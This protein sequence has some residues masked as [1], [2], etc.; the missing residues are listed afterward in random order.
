MANEADARQLTNSVERSDRF[1]DHVKDALATHLHAQ[2]DAA[3]PWIREIE[4]IEPKR[5]LRRVII[6]VVGAT[7]SGK[8][9]IINAIL[10]ET[11]LVPTNCMRACTAVV[12]EIA[13][14][15]SAQ[16]DYRAV[17]EFVS[18]REWQDELEVLLGDI[19]TGGK[20]AA[21]VNDDDSEAGIAF[22]K[23]QAVYPHLNKR[24]LPKATVDEL[25]GCD[26]IKHVVGT[27]IEFNT[28]TAEQLHEQIQK[29]VD[30]KEKLAEDF[31]T[32]GLQSSAALDEIAYWP[33]I[34]TVKIYTKSP[35]LEAG[36]VLVDLPGVADSNAARAAI[37]KKYLEKCSALWIVAPI[38]RAVDDKS[39][40]HLMSEGFK[41]QLWRD[42]TIQRMTFICSKTDEISISEARAAL[43]RYPGSGEKFEAIDKDRNAAMSERDVLQL[44]LSQ[45]KQH[46]E[47]VSESQKDAGEEEVAYKNLQGRA[48]VYPL[49]RVETAKR[50]LNEE[51]LSASSTPNKKT[52]YMDQ[53]TANFESP[54]KRTPF[55]SSDATLAPQIQF[56]EDTTQPR[57]TTLQIKK[58]LEDLKSTK[59]A[60]RTEKKSLRENQQNLKQ[61]VLENKAAIAE[62]SAREW[63][64]CVLARNEISSRAIRIDFAAGLRDI[65]QEE[66]ENPEEDEL[67]MG[68][69]DVEADYVPQVG[70]DALPVFCVSSKGFYKTSGLMQDERT[71]A[72]FDTLEGTGIPALREHVYKIGNDKKTAALQIFVDGVQRL[73]TSLRLWSSGDI[74]IGQ[75][76]ELVAGG[77]E[78]FCQELVEKFISGISKIA[79]DAMDRIARTMESEVLAALPKA[80][81]SASSAA[82]LT[83]MQW[84]ASR[85]SDNPGLH[86]Q[87]FKAVVRRTGAFARPQRPHDFNADLLHPY[88]RRIDNRWHDF[89]NVRVDKIFRDS[90]KAGAAELDSFVPPFSARLNPTGEDGAKSMMQ[91]MFDDQVKMFTK[92]Y[93]TLFKNSRTLIDEHQKSANRLFEQSVKNAMRGLYS[94]LEQET[95]TGAYD[96]CRERMKAYLDANKDIMFDEVSRKVKKKL[97]AMLEEVRGTFVTDLETSCNSLRRDCGYLSQKSR[98]F[99]ALPE[100]AQKAI[101]KVIVDADAWSAETELNDED[102]AA[103]DPA[104]L[105]GQYDMP[106]APG[107]DDTYAL[108]FRSVTPASVRPLNEDWSA[109]E[110]EETESS[111]EEDSEDN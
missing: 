70:S 91:Q 56:R 77:D 31:E 80:S 23:V 74:V 41:R 44:S 111:S 90:L 34:R 100:A 49:V 52:K 17:I 6:G 78:E 103:I 63:I 3:T 37:A 57:L 60:L 32:H 72:C 20:V 43:Q 51:V 12:T 4:Q 50:K 82:I 21:N 15:D 79:D 88:M 9:S 22:A 109:D 102:E 85:K 108:P 29:Y 101:I 84:V 5:K 61:N 83:S 53:M 73:L 95:G 13:Y 96:R 69:D 75:T 76:D 18:R 36:S 46:I 27:E 28:S 48:N 30:S 42:G 99:E 47:R 71:A 81:I 92:T 40:R 39:A 87:T 14:N 16:S 45:V 62:I 65:A 98:D 38:I 68:D 67:N 110:I 64:A 107:N 1:L 2:K 97:E 7:G 19:V 55:S 58:K 54:N 10:G 11:Q 24:N 66:N 33:L 26:Y 93:G 25:L 8:S 106:N 94:A 104:I 35:V 86:Y 105:A 89:F 59:R